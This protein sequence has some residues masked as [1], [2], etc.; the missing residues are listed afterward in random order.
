MM[1]GMPLFVGIVGLAVDMGRMYIAQSE[2]QS[3]VD[4]A[5][6]AAC[7]Q[8]DGTQTGITRANTTVDSAPNKWQFG[9]QSFTGAATQFATSA[10]GPFTSSPSNPT[11][12][13]HTLVRVTVTVP[14]Y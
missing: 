14:M 3:F 9:L 11:G 12:Y 6:L 4:A 2:A 1:L 5:A 7:L 10:T 8:L 13:Y